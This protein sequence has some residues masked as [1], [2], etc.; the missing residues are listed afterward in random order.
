MSEACVPY[1]RTPIDMRTYARA[2]ARAWRDAFGR[3]PTKGQAGV[4]YAQY[5]VETGGPPKAACW[6]W[7]I[8]N[9]KHVP[10]DGHDYYM[11]PN[12]SERINGKLV[13]FQP[14]DRAT[15]FRAYRD[16]DTAMREHF[17]FLRGKYARCWEGVE[18]EDVGVFARKLKEGPDGKEDTADDYYTATSEAYAA[19]M[20]THFRAWMASSA[21]DNALE[22]LAAEEPSVVTPEQLL[23]ESPILHPA[24]TWPEREPPES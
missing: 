16:L 18:L 2:V 17:A 10:G 9:V 20:R 8:G 4:L 12:T 19:G 24:V 6:C 14:P 3:F 23:P 13:Y 15:W 7:N 21:F 11:L 22:E 1:E 5:G